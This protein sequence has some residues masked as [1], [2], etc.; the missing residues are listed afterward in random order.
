MASPCC[1]GFRRCHL[2]IYSQTKMKE[3]RNI[4]P[5]STFRSAG[6]ETLTHM[7]PVAKSAAKQCDA[8]P[9]CE[10]LTSLLNPCDV[11]DSSCDSIRKPAWRPRIAHAALQMCTVRSAFIMCEGTHLSGWSE[12]MALAWLSFLRHRWWIAS[13]VILSV[14]GSNKPGDP[15]RA[16]KRSSI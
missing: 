8:F 6:I 16:Q 5:H 7:I 11:F 13:L 15:V 2:F 3:K 14:W 9:V 10:L 12:R 1:G 4:A